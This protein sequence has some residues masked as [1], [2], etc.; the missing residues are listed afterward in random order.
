M[1]EYRDIQGYL[2]KYITSYMEN[3][4]FTIEEQQEINT[5]DLI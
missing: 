3:Y 2:D 1:Y 4:T 5:K